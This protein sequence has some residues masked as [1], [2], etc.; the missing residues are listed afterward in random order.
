[1]PCSLF[2]LSANQA[3][4]SVVVATIVADPKL[5][6]Y[7]YSI[8]E[9]NV[10]TLATCNTELTHYFPLSRQS[11]DYLTGNAIPQIPDLWRYR[12]R[13]DHGENYTYTSN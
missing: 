1:L 2:A 10:K 13:Y 8:C 11:L 7:C 4:R 5:H 6:R 9:L 12:A 3:K